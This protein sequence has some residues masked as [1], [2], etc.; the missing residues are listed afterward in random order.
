[1]SWTWARKIGVGLDVHLPGPAELV[2]VVDV[3]GAH[4]DLQAAEHV[5]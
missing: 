5:R 2:E 3:V 1:M 4:V